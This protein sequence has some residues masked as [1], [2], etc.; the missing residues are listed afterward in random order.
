MNQVFKIVYIPLEEPSEE[1]NLDCTGSPVMELGSTRADRRGDV[2]GA[3]HR[4]SGFSPELRN[5]Y[6][7]YPLRD[8]VVFPEYKILTTQRISTLCRC[9]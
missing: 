8:L 6:R 5:R 4:G 2:P 7:F 1:P 3:K 9:I